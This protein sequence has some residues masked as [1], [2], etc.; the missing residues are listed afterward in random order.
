[1]HHL[2]V[3]VADLESVVERRHRGGQL[4]VAQIHF[5]EVLHHHVAE[6]GDVHHHPVVLLHEA[7]DRQLG[8]VVLVAEQVGDA[9]LMVEQQAILRATG[10][11]VQGV[12][13]LPQVFLG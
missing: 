6:L 1:M 12:A 10:Q 8:V 7:L 9:P 2:K 5:L 11:H 4:L 3:A 13:D